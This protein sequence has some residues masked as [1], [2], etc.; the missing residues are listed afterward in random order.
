MQATG[1]YGGP[2]HFDPLDAVD[3]TGRTVL[4]LAKLNGW[5]YLTQALTTIKQPAWALTL[6]AES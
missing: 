1:L 5:T 6:L 2:L 4:T 3:A